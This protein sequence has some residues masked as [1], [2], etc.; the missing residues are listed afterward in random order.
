ML[1]VWLE[2]SFAEGVGQSQVDVFH[3]DAG[4]ALLLEF[5]DI[6]LND[7]AI[8]VVAAAGLLAGVEAGDEEQDGE[9]G[10]ILFHHVDKVVIAG[11]S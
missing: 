11:I 2:Y 8:V 6:V 3:I 10:E 9:E 4:E 7:I 1:Q 5:F